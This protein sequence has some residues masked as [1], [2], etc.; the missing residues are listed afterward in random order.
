MYHVVGFTPEAPTKQDVIGDEIQ[1]VVFD[2]AAYDKVCEK[3]SQ[4]GPIDFVVLG[5][6]HVSIR[7]FEEIAGLVRGKRLNSDLWVCTSR[8]VRELAERMGFVEDIQAAGGE[9]ICD[10]CPVLCCTLT[11]RGYK[12]V[13]T[14]SGKMAHYAPGLWNLQ[15]VLLNT[16]ECIQAAIDGKWGE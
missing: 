8:M 16:A 7:E 5:C 4:K 15:P 1:P 10:T 11:Q 3:F 14:N 2:Q 13:A 6:P 12:T 9:I